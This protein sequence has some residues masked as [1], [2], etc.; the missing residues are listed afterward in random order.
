MTSKIK[1]KKNLNDTQFMKLDVNDFD[2]DNQNDVAQ[3]TEINPVDHENDVEMSVI[4]F[5]KSRACKTSKKFSDKKYYSFKKIKIV[6][7]KFSSNTQN[8]KNEKETD[9]KT[10]LISYQF[11]NNC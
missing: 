5:V 8:T 10:K 11:E 9:S 6:E 7:Y 3:F 2:S 1:I 4:G